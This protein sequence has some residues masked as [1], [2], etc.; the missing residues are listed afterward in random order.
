MWY[1]LYRTLVMNQLPSFILGQNFGTSNGAGINITDSTLNSINYT[2]PSQQNLTLMESA[3]QS[4]QVVNQYEIVLHLGYGTNGNQSYSALLATISSPSAFAVDPSYVSKYGG[5]TANSPNTYMQTNAMGTGFY[6]LSSWI[7]GQSVKL[8]INP[9]YWAKN[10]P[11]SQLNY[12]LQPATLS[13]VIIYYKPTSSR[14]ADLKSGFAQIIGAPDV[15]ETASLN[16]IRSIP[17]VN[18]TIFPIQFG[19]AEAAYYV[20]MNPFVNPVFSNINVREAV[21][22]AINYSGIISSVFSGL[23]Q[24]WIGPVPPGFPYYNQT[25]SGLSQYTYDPVLAAQ[26][27][28]KAGYVSKLPNGTKTRSVRADFPDAEFCLHHRFGFRK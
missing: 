18:V 26:L 10:L 27:L 13:S 2:S 15:T 6:E 19:S 11:S 24:Q 20:F 8:V 7:Q 5:V 12:A 1:S 16:T 4:F 9:N 25:T 23:A 17:N 14:I 22:Y 3:N 28:A 21:S